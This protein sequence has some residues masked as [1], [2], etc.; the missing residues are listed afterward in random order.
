MNH[1]I[2]YGERQ[3]KGLLGVGFLCEINKLEWSVKTNDPLMNHQAGKPI[4]NRITYGVRQNRLCGFNQGIHSWRVRLTNS[5]QRAR[6][7]SKS[8]G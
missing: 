2:R 5:L 4:G 7:I 8:E 1:N 6:A 3:E